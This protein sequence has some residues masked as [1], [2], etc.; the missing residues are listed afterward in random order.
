VFYSKEKTRF[1]EAKIATKKI[2]PS[3]CQS[4]VK[5]CFDSADCGDPTGAKLSIAETLELE[6]PMGS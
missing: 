4:S 1:L 3:F 2:T 6:T 5:I